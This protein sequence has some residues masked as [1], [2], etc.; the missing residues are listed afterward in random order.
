MPEA[1]GAMLDWI[2]A[3]GV[4]EVLW[5]TTVGNTS[6]LSV[7]RSSGFTFTGTRDAMFTARDG[8]HPAAWHAA[9]A[10]TDTRAPKP[11][12]PA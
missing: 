6:S 5:E 12:W 4:G 2:F 10:A 8:T 11:G 3:G 1:V 7:A 9:L